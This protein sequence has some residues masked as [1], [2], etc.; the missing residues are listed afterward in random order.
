MAA[1]WQVILKWALAYG[2]LIDVPHEVAPCSWID[3]TYDRARIVDLVQDLGR[4]GASMMH[5]IVL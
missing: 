1:V 5:R 2:R 3:S 4:T